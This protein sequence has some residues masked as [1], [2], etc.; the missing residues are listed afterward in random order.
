MAA[1]SSIRRRFCAAPATH[2]PA[3]PDPATIRAMGLRFRGHER[4]WLAR[5]RR[6]RSSRSRTSARRTPDGR[7]WPRDRRSPR[8]RAARAGRRRRMRRSFAGAVRR[9]AERCRSASPLVGDARPGRVRPRARGRLCCRPRARRASA[10]VGVPTVAM[11]LAGP[12]DVRARSVR[13]GGVPDALGGHG[14][15]VLLDHRPSVG[16]TA[17]ASWAPGRGLA[18]LGADAARGS[19][20]A[21][22]HPRAFVPRDQGPR[23]VARGGLADRVPA[24]W[25][26]CP[27]LPASR[28]FGQGR[29]CSR[30]PLRGRTG[31]RT[32]PGADDRDRNPNRPAG[33]PWQG[34]WARRGDPSGSWRTQAIDP[35]GVSCEPFFEHCH[36][37]STAVTIA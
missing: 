30:S 6:T 27:P 17:A 36:V 31:R 22:G 3:C 10:R 18:R 20:L 14:A 35:S 33:V 28:C 1:D 25:H 32:V 21:G 11:L 16:P 2:P 15:G 5:R 37:A 34:H 12:P 4:Y 29:A 13:R 23:L 9:L 26:S 8:P 7:R 24:S 19:M